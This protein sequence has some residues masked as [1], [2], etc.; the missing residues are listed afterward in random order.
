MGWQ[1]LNSHL[2]DIKLSSNFVITI[3]NTQETDR[4]IVATTDPITANKVNDLDN[5]PFIIEGDGP[6]AL[7]IYF[8]SEATRLEYLS[9]PLRTTDSYALEAYTGDSQ[10]AISGNFH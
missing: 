2:R 8:E 3:P 9:L 4:M 10:L 5:A 7:I 1:N 6:H